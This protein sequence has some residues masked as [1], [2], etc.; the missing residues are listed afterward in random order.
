MALSVPSKAQLKTLLLHKLYTVSSI[1]DH[2]LL[3]HVEVKFCQVRGSTEIPSKV[4]LYYKIRISMPNIYTV[5]VHIALRKYLYFR[6]EVLEH[7]TFTA[8]QYLMAKVIWDILK[9]LSRAEI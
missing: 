4:V 1:P 8:L 7:D 9:V 2:E 3:M 6:V 5:H